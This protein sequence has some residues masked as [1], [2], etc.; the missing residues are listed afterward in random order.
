MR[1]AYCDTGRFDLMDGDPRPAI[2]LTLYLLFSVLIAA[3]GMLSGPILLLR[4]SRLDE[5]WE[6][7]G[8][9]S[10]VPKVEL[11]VEEDSDDLASVLDELP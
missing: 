4:A 3:G 5:M 9:L 10:P 1:G 11:N 2:P 7:G 8:V 6:I